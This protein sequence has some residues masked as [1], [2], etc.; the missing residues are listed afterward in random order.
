MI[1]VD[2]TMVPPF[3]DKS[4]QRTVL[5]SVPCHTASDRIPVTVPRRH[6]LEQDT[7]MVSAALRSLLKVSV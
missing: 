1:Q 7:A 4:K 6:G 2:Y 3:T 5:S